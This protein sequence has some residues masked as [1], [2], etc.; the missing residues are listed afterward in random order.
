MMGNKQKRIRRLARFA[1]LGVGFLAL[2][3]WASPDTA[4][5]DQG[6]RRGHRRG[7]RIEHRHG[8]AP[9]YEKHKRYYGKRGH[10]FHGKRYYRHGRFI[11]PRH[12]HRHHVRTYRPYYTGRA[13]FRPHRHNHVVYYF[14]VATPYGYYEY[15]PHFYCDG[16]LF[17]SGEFGSHGS[18][19]GFSLSF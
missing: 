12:I 15:R 18:H 6:H 11:V 4:F 13:Y 10:H 9:K 14:P 19:I 16:K 17:I 5:A 2:S 8:P 1:A 7:H 3:L